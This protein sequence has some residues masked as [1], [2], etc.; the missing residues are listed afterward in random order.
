[1]DID[2]IVHK[3]QARTLQIFSQSICNSGAYD[4]QQ[5]QK[6]EAECRCINNEEMEEFYETDEQS[7]YCQKGTVLAKAQIWRIN[8]RDLSPKKL[9]IIADGESD[10]FYRAASMMIEFMEWDFDSALQYA[11]DI[12]CCD[13]AFYLEHFEVTKEF[14]NRGLG[15]KLAKEVLSIAGATGLPF[16]IWPANNENYADGTDPKR[17]RNFWMNLQ[18]GMAWSGKWETAYHRCFG[19][20]AI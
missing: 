12:N 19:E 2:S 10:D 3:I 13:V 17:L 14:R 15:N 4:F 18:D 9:F 16:F 8:I 20:S 11:D 7:L 5:I 6:I 1:M